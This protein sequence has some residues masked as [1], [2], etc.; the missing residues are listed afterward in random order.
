MEISREEEEEE[1]EEEDETIRP[2]DEVIVAERIELLRLFALPLA[3]PGSQ[4]ET[5]LK[6]EEDERR[7]REE[8]EK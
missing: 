7:R 5:H 6:V 1:E 4:L 3:S 2:Q 8:E